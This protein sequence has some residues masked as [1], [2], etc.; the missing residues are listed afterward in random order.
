VEAPNKESK[1]L[2]REPKRTY[3]NTLMQEPTR[4][5][6]LIDIVLPKFMKSN[7]LKELPNV[8]VENWEMLL[9]NLA[10]ALRE[11]EEAKLTKSKTLHAEPILE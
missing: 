2:N 1:T 11:Q 8:T 10:T 9:P 5:F 7:M 6:D 3:E 4:T